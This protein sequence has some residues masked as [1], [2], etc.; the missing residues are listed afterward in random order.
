MDDVA[1]IVPQP[2]AETSESLPT[3]RKPVTDEGIKSYMSS[4]V[5]LEHNNT[6]VLVDAFRFTSPYKGM[7]EREL[8]D[9]VGSTPG[10]FD[11]VYFLSHYHSDHYTGLHP[12][13]KYGRI[14]TGEVTGD[15]LVHHLGMPT[16]RVIRLKRNR[17]Y[18][19]SLSQRKLLHE[20]EMAG[21][22]EYCA[23]WSCTDSDVLQVTLINANH[24]PGAEMLIF[25]HAQCGTILH[26]GDFRYNGSTDTCPSV[27]KLWCPAPLLGDDPILKTLRNCVDV[28]FLDNTFCDPAF[29]F[30]RQEE[31]F[32]TALQLIKDSILNQYYRKYTQR[33]VVVTS[34]DD[35]YN[36]IAGSEVQ[37]CSCAQSGSNE[38]KQKKCIHVAIMVGAYTI[39]KERIALAIREALCATPIG[40][41]RLDAHPPVHVHTQK[42]RLLESTDFCGD[43]FSVISNSCVESKPSDVAS[44]ENVQEHI[45]S[46]QP[47]LLASSI[48]FVETEVDLKVLSDVI[49]ST[50]ISISS[51]VSTK[52]GSKKAP[53]Q[54]SSSTSTT[55]GSNLFNSLENLVDDQVS[56]F[57]TIFLTP[58]QA[59]SYPNLSSSARED[60]SA[61]PSGQHERPPRSLFIWDKCYLPLDLF[62]SVVCIEPTGW[63]APKLQH[64]GPQIIARKCEKTSIPYSE[65]SSF[66]ELLEFVGY[67][68]PK[69]IVPTVSV[70]QFKKQEPRFLEACSKLQANYGVMTPLT[71]FAHL[72][73]SQTHAGELLEAAG[74]TK[75]VSKPAPPTSFFASLTGSTDSLLDGDSKNG[76]EV[77]ASRNS[78]HNN[79]SRDSELNNEIVRKRSREEVIV[80]EVAQQSAAAPSRNNA[81]QR[82]YSSL[83][84][85]K[86]GSVTIVDDDDDVVFISS[87]KVCIEVD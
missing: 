5:V 65:H 59:L 82:T 14:F 35:D 64:K 45:V 23:E 72:F 24:C 39:G 75:P 25:K 66:P 71:R 74:F 11:C 8:R 83:S 3:A 86:P 67:L 28:L 36:N 7:K 38:S 15:L 56:C 43:H 9:T 47:R 57:A 55:T 81:H 22:Q 12:N 44:E 69:K 51:T 52:P 32:H 10:L 6:A 16:D 48:D 76:S 29:V 84:R 58:L 70:E 21:G 60:V 77:Q 46:S 17:S 27:S 78:S 50:S 34:G 68:K 79:D 18:R 49:D 54:R 62:D 19:I 80:N 37:K 33:T 85:K 42:K 53:F 31:S 61:T 41:V 87:T 40:E 73:R 26:T 20:D 13:W 63:A 1:Q 4:R 30:P 2:P